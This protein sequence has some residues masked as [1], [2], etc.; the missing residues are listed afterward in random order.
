MVRF[1]VLVVDSFDVGAVKDV[2]L[3]RPQ[4]AGASTYGHTLNQLPYL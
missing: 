1:V 4:D 2:T 3:A